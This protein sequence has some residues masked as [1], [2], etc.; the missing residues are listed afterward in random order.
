[1]K[2][3]QTKIRRQFHSS[4][5]TNSWIKSLFQVQAY[6]PPYEHIIQIG[7]PILRKISDPV[8]VDLIMSHEIK[9]LIR[10][11]R[12]VYKAYD[13]VGIASPQ[14]G[15]NLRVIIMGFDEKLKKNFS[16]EVYKAKE[17]EALPEIVIINPELQILDY[18]KKVF[19]E[20]CASIRGYSGDVDR[21][22]KVVHSKI[23]IK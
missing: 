16:P 9:F 20:S 17:M 5:T 23:L 10:K 13:L 3:C 1:L 4:R 19:E 21:Y 12:K 11:M 22:Q 8:P 2:Q 6:E 18:N 15:I 7:D 14:I